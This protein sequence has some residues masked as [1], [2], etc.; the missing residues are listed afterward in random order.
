MPKQKPRGKFWPQ[1]RALIWEKAQELYQMENAK[2]MKEDFKGTTATRK[3]LREGGYFHMA[4]LMVLRE[5]HR[6]R[7]NS[8]T[9]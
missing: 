6:K 9:F 7:K 1:V 4:K 3:E 2:T 5:L 8:E